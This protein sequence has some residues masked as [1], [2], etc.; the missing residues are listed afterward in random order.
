MARRCRVCLVLGGGGVRG[1]AHLGVLQVFESAG[2][3]IDY[4]VGT[5]AG[6]IV[7]AA[8]AIQPDA[9]RVTA[10]ALEYFSGEEFAASSFSYKYTITF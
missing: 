1:L 2:I 3:P 9:E 6:S 4:L 8:Y 5:S 7:G 10:R